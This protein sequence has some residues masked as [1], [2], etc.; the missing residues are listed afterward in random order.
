MKGPI[1]VYPHPAPRAH[2]TEGLDCWCGPAFYVPCDECEDGCWKCQ[3]GLI[4]VDRFDAER[5][6]DLRVV[7]QD[8]AHAA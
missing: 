5:A 8:V 2:A 6:D 7:H 1:H 3:A 4:P